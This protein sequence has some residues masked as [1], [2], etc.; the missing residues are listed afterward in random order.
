MAEQP[1]S[2]FTMNSAREAISKGFKHIEEPVNAIEAAVSENTGL[3]F[4]L[5]R[6]LVEST[7]KTILTERGVEYN[8]TDEL[9]KL[10]RMVR[11]NLP[12]LPPQESQATNVRQSIQQ[13]LSGLSG[14]IQGITELRNRLGFA[15]HGSDKRRP[16][17][18]PV[19]AILAAQVA[20]TIVGFLYHI[21]TQDRN[22]PTSPESSN[23]RNSEF[24]SFIDES[25]DTVRIFESEFLPSDILFQMEPDSYRIGLADFLSEA[26]SS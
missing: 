26:D 5:A 23:D 17:M 19:H 2:S 3:A 21:H 6:T 20:D 11:E 7:C 18:E 12:I 14:T 15:S 8:A 13:T 22:S 4:D 10:F 25:H 16:L 1:E 24:D 9:P